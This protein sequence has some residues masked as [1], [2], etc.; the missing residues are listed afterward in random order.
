MN[1]QAHKLRRLV[2]DK[3]QEKHHISVLPESRVIK[4]ENVMLQSRIIAVT[5]GKGGVGKTNLTVN[6][7]IALSMMGQKVL[8]IDADLGM[9]NVDVVLG[10]SSKYSLLNLI[11]DD[12]TI[13]D[14]LTEGPYGIKYL[15]GGSGMEKLINFTIQEFEHITKKLYE[16]EGFADI[17]LID[18]GAGLGQNVL[19]FLI[20]SDEVIL[21]TTPEPTAMTDAYAIMKAYSAY[22]SSIN[23]KLIVNRVFDENEGS[24]VIDKLVR[25]AERFL[26][27]HVVPLGEIYEDR[28]MVKAVKAQTPLLLSYPNTISAK[29]IRAVAENLLDGGNVTVSRGMKGFLEKFMAYLR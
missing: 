1:D 8:I 24:V 27:L 15:S 29:C 5:S 9:A 4:R 11:E 10:A 2:E 28:N 22:A 3:Q 7:A 14:V 18:T 25:A 20:A 12:I 23:M 16:C 26:R 21:V 13:M 17:I 6:L 19:N